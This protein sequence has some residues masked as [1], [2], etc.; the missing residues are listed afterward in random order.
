[1]AASLGVPIYAI[2]AG[3]P[4]AREPEPREAPAETPA[5]PGQTRAQAVQTMRDLARMTSGQYFPARD[6]AALLKA[7]RSIDALERT[8]IQSFQYRRYHEGYPYCA[9]AALALFAAALGLDL[10]VWRR[11]P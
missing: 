10:T 7:W 1:V 8:D 9:L 4:G 6:T 5:S 3:G 2:D 11:V